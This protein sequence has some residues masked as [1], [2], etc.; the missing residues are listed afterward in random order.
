MQ[1]VNGCYRHMLHA[2]SIQCAARHCNNVS[3]ALTDRQHW[4][5]TA[6]RRGD[7]VK[8]RRGCVCPALIAT[9]GICFDAAC[10]QAQD[11]IFLDVIG[12]PLLCL[13]VAVIYQALKSPGEGTFQDSETGAVFESVDGSEPERDLKGELV[14]RAQS[15]TPWPVD[16]GAEGERIRI[17][18]GPIGQRRPRTYVFKRRLGSGS[19]LITAT[20]TRP[21]GIVFEEDAVRKRVLVSTFIPSSAAGRMAKRAALDATAARKAPA[22]GDVLRACTCTN[23]VYPKDS[24]FGAKLPQRH[25]VVYG[26]DDETWPRVINALRNGDRTDGDVTLILERRA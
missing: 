10:Q 3:R 12:F 16:Q 11:Q 17:P 24:L 21:L 6:S 19:R 13:I 25:V 9:R 22:V 23:I 20:L 7:C 2:S 8:F 5:L 18:V 1:H 26:A 14:F 15:Y 4:Q